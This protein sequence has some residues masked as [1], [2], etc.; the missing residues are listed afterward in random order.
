MAVQLI[1]I[2]HAWRA[3]RESRTSHQFLISFTGELGNEVD[4]NFLRIIK[5]GKDH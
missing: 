4:A 3:I 2:L 5:V 1:K